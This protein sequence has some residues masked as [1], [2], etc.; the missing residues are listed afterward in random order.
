MEAAIAA[1]FEGGCGGVGFAGFTVRVTFAEWDKLPLEP[2]MVSVKVP[3]AAEVVV[4]TFKVE[5][6][7]PLM[8]AGVKLDDAPDGSPVTLSATVPVKPFSA[9]VLTV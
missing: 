6:P 7:A 9:P 3:V 4:V 1:R 5:E 2:V 8:E